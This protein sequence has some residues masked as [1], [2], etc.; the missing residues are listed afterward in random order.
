MNAVSPKQEEPEED[1]LV[2]SLQFTSVSLHSS[3][4]LQSFCVLIFVGSTCEW[5]L[6]KEVI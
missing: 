2:A 1:K 4:L 5:E 6:V 3:L